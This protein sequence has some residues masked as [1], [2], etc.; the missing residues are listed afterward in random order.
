MGKFQEVV[1]KNHVNAPV[2]FIGC[3]GVGSRIIR[4][5]ANRAL[6]DDTSNL[7]FVVM[8]TDVNDISK[9]DTG[10]NIIP[11]QTSSTATIERY[12][13]NDANAKENWFPVNKMLDSKSVSEGAG[14]V[15]SISRLALNAT[16]KKGKIMTLYKAI[17]DLY[18]KDGGKFKQ[19]IKVVIASTAA[20]GT[21]SGIAMEVGMLVRNYIH[22]NYP[23]AAVMIRGFLVMPGCLDT[24]IETQSER[25]SIRCNGYATIKEINA[26]MIKGSGF[27]DTV[28]ELKR[29]KNLH[30]S[31]PNATAGEEQLSN[32]PFD[33]CFLMDRADSNSGIMP[34]M[35]QYEEY[36]ALALYEQNIGPMSTSTSSKEDNVLKLCIR[37]ETLGRCR[38]GGAG[39][40]RLIYPYDKIRD[41]LALNWSRTAIIGT[42]ANKDLSE[43]EK[44]DLIKNS[45]LQ[46]DLKFKEE[47]K[48]YDENPA[49]SEEPTLGE[50]Y[51][52]AMTSGKDRSAG[53]PFTASLWEKYLDSKVLDIKSGEGGK[54]TLNSPDRVNILSERVEA[55]SATEKVARAYVASIIQ[56]V[57]DKKLEFYDST[58]PEA[59]ESAQAQCVKDTNRTH[60]RKLKAIQSIADIAKEGAEKAAEDLATAIFNS[61]ASASNDRL[62]EYMLEKYISAK[63]KAM[64]PNAVRFVLYELRKFIDNASGIFKTGAD[65]YAYEALASRCEQGNDKEKNSKEFDVPGLKAR[66]KETTL[67]AMCQACDDAGYFQENDAGQSC[68]VKLTTYA[69]H[70]INY[71]VNKVGH[72]ICRVAAPALDE[73]IKA[74]EQFYGTFESKVPDLEKKKE[75]IAT[76]LQ[77]KNGDHTLYLFENQKLLN[78]LSA[79][80]ATPAESGTASSELYAEI[81]DNVRKN[82]KTLARKKYSN[83]DYS[84][85]LDIFNDVIVPY[86]TKMVEETVSDINVDNILQAA[87]LEYKI[88]VNLRLSET[89]PA[90]QEETR[91]AIDTEDGMKKHIADTIARCKNLA[92]PGILKNI[93]DEDREVSAIAYSNSLR[94]GGGIRVSEFLHDQKPTD[95]VSAYELH[96]FRSVYNVTPLQLSKLAAPGED[97]SNDQF[98]L[99][100]QDELQLPSTGEYFRV[101][102][103]YMNTVGPDSKISAVITPHIDQRWNSISVMPEMDMEYQ[104]KLMSKIHKSMLYGFLFD[105]IRMRRYSEDDSEQKIYFYLD[106]DEDNKEMTVSNK[107]KCDEL[108]EVLDCLYFD[109]MAVS[110]I[111]DFVNEVRVKQSERGCKSI[112]D[113]DFF[114]ALSMLTRKQILN[115]PEGVGEEII[116]LFE[117]VLMY[118][119]SLPAKNK[120]VSEMKI[121]I[122]SIIEMLQAEVSVFTSNPDTILS[123]TADILMQQYRLFVSNYKKFNDS[124]CIGI[125]SDEV[126]E[127]TK[128]SLIR[129]FKRQDMMKYVD[130]VKEI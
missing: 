49:G 108:Y 69:R 71:L 112:A 35:K 19:G 129:Y 88:L 85:T 64:H 23:E 99:T 24:V 36:A 93:H 14:Q 16:V 32:L 59:Y 123:R 27:F 40:S 8:D 67:M 101:Y 115:L 122:S 87:K 128:N 50:V 15:R 105:R 13:K 92:S 58:F 80:N 9:V 90:L 66:G 34:S 57:I 38:F 44:A 126:V 28:P 54:V 76:S 124:L 117:I 22:K 29:Y 11:V 20:G 103:E 63:G 10:A 61:T 33:F 98:A 7:R 113:S 100:S 118:C 107:T 106:N 114:K 41:Y 102:Q 84:P 68:E 70:T 89:T 17:D 65:D 111:R 104:R 26:F 110:I 51:I 96:F 77:F 91:L 109:R 30:I 47:K 18:L 79:L 5:V 60:K 48:K 43:E 1:Q 37:P 45:W 72:H 12:L 3:G 21:G 127:Y 55:N 94:D 39:A 95:T 116:S 73:L 31:V 125:F 6:H 74:F 52:R 82:A 4:G 119:N 62:G 75:D 53:N 86:Y 83:Y 42:S 97:D 121:M 120:D 46:Y 130:Q 2:I 25:D 81:F 56:E 78:R